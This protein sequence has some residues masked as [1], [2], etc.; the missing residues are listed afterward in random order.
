M[1]GEPFVL[2]YALLGQCFCQYSQLIYIDPGEPV[3]DL[4]VRV[5]ITEKKP[6]TKLHVPRLRND[7]STEEGAGK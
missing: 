2:P 4:S 1:S 6:I 5:S 3:S 7:V